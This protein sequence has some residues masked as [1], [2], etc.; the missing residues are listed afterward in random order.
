MKLTLPL[1]FC[2]AALS[3]CIT[4]NAP[5]VN[6]KEEDVQEN[7]NGSAP[8]ISGSPVTEASINQYYSFTP[9]AEDADEDPLTFS[10]E[11][12]PDWAD[13]DTQNGN[14][15][16]MPTGQDSYQSIIISVTDGTHTTSLDAFGINVSQPAAL[17]VTIRWQAP[18]EDINDDP[19]SGIQAYK[20][21]YG[22]IQGNY[23]QSVTINNGNAS[24]YIIQDL[25]PGDYFFTMV[26][27]TNNGMESAMS[28][29]YYF[30]VGQ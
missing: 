13:F 12:L 18:T 20:I 5:E 15:S 26:A 22:T 11:N 14:I 25:T 9:D 28:T 30:Q 2:S 27:I 8:T 23:D 1:V 6:E 16:G 4:I 19:L 3:G 24:E 7:T 21:F 29:E 10:V 17:G